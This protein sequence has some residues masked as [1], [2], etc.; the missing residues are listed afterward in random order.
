MRTILRLT[1]VAALTAAPLLGQG[2]GGAGRGAP[3]PRRDTIP[4]R[5]APDGDVLDFQN[6]D[7]TVVLRAIAEAGG[8]SVSIQNAP[9]NK[10][11]TLRIQAQMSKD[12]ATEILKAIAEGAG[13]TVTQS[14]SLIRLVGPAQAAAPPQLTA[15]QQLQQMLGARNRVVHTVR[16]KYARASTVAPMLMSLFR[17]TT[18]PGVAGVNNGRGGINIPGVINNAA[19][20]A[21]AAGAGAGGRGGRGGGAGAAGGGG[22]GAANF[23]G[24]R[25]AAAA[26]PLAGL[27]GIQQALGGAFGLGG[28]YGQPFSDM[29]IIGDD[30]TNSLIFLSTEE[31]YQVVAPLVQSVDLRPLQVLI[32]VMIAQVE[33][34]H[35]LNVGVSG[36]VN[37]TQNAKLGAGTTTSPFRDTS[38]VQGT[39]ASLPSA[40]TA[41]DFVAAL[42]GAKGNINYDIALNALQTRGN[43]RVMA[44]PILIAQNNVQAVINVGANVP[45][46]QVSQT[47]PNDPTGRVQTVQYQQV[48][49]TLTITPTI[50]ADGYVNMAV[51]QT[52]DDVT[53]NVLFD[54]P[55]INQ[56]QAQTQVF[57]KDGQTTVLG[58][59]ADD[60]QDNTTSGIPILNKIPFFGGWLFG[61]THKN[62][63]TTELYL[64][65]TP[66]IVSTD[67]DVDRLRNSIQSGSELLKGAPL[68]VINPGADTIKIGTPIKPPVP[69]VRRDTLVPPPKDSTFTPLVASREFRF[70]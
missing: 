37:K 9:T 35:D 58:G 1:F 52:N 27:G 31:D 50:N 25:G 48:G 19:G 39:L 6:Q 15:Q 46:V 12:A 17:G 68:K 3:P 53:S 60:T 54:A 65:L 20:G 22:A 11:V 8:L 69:P 41:R 40:A 10:P 23:G 70:E 24:G 49:K 63:T 47:V 26:N 64:F 30:M 42:I 45:F 32:E 38:I 36:T 5:A 61:N 29:Q 14:A 34:T 55:I 18:T 59:L 57:V 43:V 4:V 56:R 51:Q 66:H 67:E 62:R 13:F 2:G 28:L 16:L 44:T 21:G 7:V 33:R